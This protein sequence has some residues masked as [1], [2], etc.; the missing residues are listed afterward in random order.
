MQTEAESYSAQGPED[1]IEILY[2]IFQDNLIYQ[3]QKFSSGTYAGGSQ[4]IRC[5]LD[6]L[7]LDEINIVLISSKPIKEQYKVM[8]TPHFLKTYR[9]SNR[10][11]WR[12]GN[13]ADRAV[14]L[15]R[16]KD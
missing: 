15:C 12:G 3:I 8:H 16:R 10:S 1:L 4:E 2:G 9:R 14:P 6:A 13:P 5:V 11:I 7:Y